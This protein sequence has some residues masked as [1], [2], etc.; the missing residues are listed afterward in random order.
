MSALAGVALL[1]PPRLDLDGGPPPSGVGLKIVDGRN[2]YSSP[3]PLRFL[4]E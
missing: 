1:N 2:Y 4:V 3:V